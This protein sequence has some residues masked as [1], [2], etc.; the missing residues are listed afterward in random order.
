MVAWRLSPMN[1]KS[2]GGFWR[3]L[4][5]VDFYIAAGLLLVAGVL[6]VMRPGISELLENFLE[7]GIFPLSLVLF[8]ARW[9]SWMEI[10]FALVALSGW[11]A[12]WCARGLAALYLLFAVLIAVAADGYWLSPIDCGC[13]GSGARTPAYLLLLRNVLIAFPLFFAGPDFGIGFPPKAHASRS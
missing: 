1:C 4:V 13:F 11:Q 2:S 5:V 8:L 6:K 9:Q 10:V 7:Q 12:R 3:L